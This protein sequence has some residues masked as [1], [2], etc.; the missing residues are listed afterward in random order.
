MV[1]ALEYYLSYHKVSLRGVAIR[2]KVK[3]RYPV[4][5]A[6][7]IQSYLRFAVVV[8]LACSMLGCATRFSPEIIREE[9]VQQRGQAPLSVF[10]LN[11]GR[12]TTLLI[13]STL[14]QH[15]NRDDLPFAGL[16][17]LHLAVYEAPSE[18][19]PAIDVTM[20]PIRGWEPLVRLHNESRSGV[21]LIR[22]DSEVISD[23]VIVGA[24]KRKVVYARLRGK[25]SRDLPAALGDILRYEGP[26]GVRSILTT[27]IKE[28][29]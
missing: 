13:R 16:Q 4:R 10:E 9:I 7:M 22:P 18:L 14:T 12:F 25:L 28:T 5:G 1:L 21:L 29:P 8:F 27:L 15:V 24:S 2:A 3:P 6:D 26:E 17:Q 11:L 19:G 20:I 23:L